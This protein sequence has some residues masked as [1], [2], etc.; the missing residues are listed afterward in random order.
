MKIGIDLRVLARGTRTGV[1]EYTINITRALIEGYPEVEFR[2]F[3]NAF[4]KAPLSF[5]WLAWPN[6]R[7]VESGFPNR[8]LNLTGQIAGWPKIDTVLGGVDVLFSPHFVWANVQHAKRVVTV[9]GLEFVRYPEFFSLRQ[10][11]WHRAMRPRVQLQKADRVIAV[12]RSTK[13]DL[14]SLYGIE[15]EKI[16]VVYEG[17]DQ[18]AFRRVPDDAVSRYRKTNGLPE[19]FILCLATIEPR[20]NMVSL[21]RAFAA[22]RQNGAAKDWR[23]VICGNRGWGWQKVFRA[24]HDLNLEQSVLFFSCPPEEKPIV[25]SAASIFVFPSYLEGFGLP[26]LEAMSVGLPVIVSNR[27]SLPEVVGDA[28]LSVDP[29]HDGEL[30]YAL[31]HLLQDARLREELS[32]RGIERSRQFTWEKAARGTFAIFAEVCQSAK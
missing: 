17:V 9:H 21:L 13:N 5:P 26:P 2:L 22:L 29:W 1:E 3:Y 16:S 25:Y 24:V 11:S 27:S 15:P 14:V 30:Q 23:V 4:R 12:S 31:G 32:R 20:K 8:F 7:L 19:R 10:R 18:S 6:V 28:G